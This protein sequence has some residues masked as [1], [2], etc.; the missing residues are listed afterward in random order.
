MAQKDI[1]PPP[2]SKTY[3]KPKTIFEVKNRSIFTTSKGD[4]KQKEN[5]INVTSIQLLF[6][7]KSKT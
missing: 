4:K 3:F 6:C 5:H 1:S 2:S 7:P